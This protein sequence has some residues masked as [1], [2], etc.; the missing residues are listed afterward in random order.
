VERALVFF[1]APSSA[2][3]EKGM[4]A[5]A[6]KST[7]SRQ[8]KQSLRMYFLSGIR[9]A[10]FKKGFEMSVCLI[11]RIG[12]FFNKWNFRPFSELLGRV[13]LKCRINRPDSFDAVLSRFC[14]ILAGDHVRGLRSTKI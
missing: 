7:S 13:R 1:A 2:V 3:A 5:R 14:D 8:K 6:K 9:T 11:L 10:F 12:A 4:Q